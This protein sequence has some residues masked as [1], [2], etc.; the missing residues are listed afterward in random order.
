MSATPEEVV[1]D[2][3]KGTEERVR[4]AMKGQPNALIYYSE[5]GTS[6]GVVFLP[7][8]LAEKV[9]SFI[10]TMQGTPTEIHGR[11]GE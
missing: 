1:A 2:V 11:I 5:A 9:F 7:G 4:M 3:L 8:G 6:L 10:D